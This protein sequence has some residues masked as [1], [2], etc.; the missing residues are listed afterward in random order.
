VRRRSA[1]LQFEYPTPRRSAGHELF[2]PRQAS[3]LSPSIYRASPAKTALERT[4]LSLT[5]G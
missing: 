4:L 3:K 2:S 1:D 5:F